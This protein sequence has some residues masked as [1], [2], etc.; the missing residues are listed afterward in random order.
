MD[1]MRQLQGFPQN[2]NTFAPA[3]PNAQGFR[4]TPQQMFEGVTPQQMNTARNGVRNSVGLPPAPMRPLRPAMPG[5]GAM[6]PPPARSVGPVGPQQPGGSSLRP[7]GSVTMN[8]VYGQDDGKQGRVNLPNRFEDN[9]SVPME[10]LREQTQYGGGATTGVAAGL[11]PLPPH[12]QD[13]AN[14]HDNK[15]GAT[16]QYEAPGSFGQSQFDAQQAQIAQSRART[17]AYKSNMRYPQ[18]PVGPVGSNLPDVNDPNFTPI[19]AQE[20]FRQIPGNIWQ[21]MENR[22]NKLGNEPIDNSLPDMGP[23][24]EF[25]PKYAMPVPS[26]PRT[27]LTPQQQMEIAKRTAD[28]QEIA[29]QKQAARFADQD[30]RFKNTARQDAMADYKHNR[31]IQGRQKRFMM[32]NPGLFTTPDFT[33][34]QLA[35]SLGQGSLRQFQNQGL[36]PQEA[37][38]MQLQVRNQGIEEAQ[39]WQSQGDEG[40]AAQAM[41]RANQ[42]GYP[43]Q[44]TNTIMGGYPGQQGSPAP[45]DPRAV[46]N[47]SKRF[48]GED[49]SLDSNSLGLAID[50]IP[51]DGNLTPDAILGQG[52]TEPALAQYIQGIEGQWN[53]SAE[54]RIRLDRAK[55]A[56]QIIQ[57]NG[58]G[59]RPT[60]PP[61]PIQPF[62]ARPGNNLNN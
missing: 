52:I 2:R 43:G 7:A 4:A 40:R 51:A 29:N 28:A 18:V 47:N 32:E 41:D 6:P 15:F 39:F 9:A 14:Q 42:F 45:L 50:S 57:G 24:S 33:A 22:L 30:R 12:L 34:A 19:T 11:G 38:A 13:Y 62:G 54:D 17:D 25:R 49:G 35:S 37:A 20:A 60:Q 61:A 16:R 26:K 21:G 31:M 3:A 5:P 10:R 59:Q 8:Y 36:S 53:P 23:I 46:F 55:R 44:N 27:P 58:Q 56:L 1:G 48:R